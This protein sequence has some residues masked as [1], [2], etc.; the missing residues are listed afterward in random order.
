MTLERYGRFKVNCT[1]QGK[2]LEILCAAQQGCAVVR[3]EMLY[4]ENAFEVIA[5][6][7]EFDAV[8]RG[9]LIPQYDVTLATDAE[10]VTHRL[11]FE[12]L[13]PKAA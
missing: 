4:A 10:G 6:H 13:T 2:D 9:Q 11:G 3:C 5:W 1:A 12:R 7:P 8:P